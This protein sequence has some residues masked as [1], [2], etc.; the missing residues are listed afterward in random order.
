MLVNGS[1]PLT[2]VIRSAAF[3]ELGSLHAKD[4]LENMD[5]SPSGLKKTFDAVGLQPDL[6]SMLEQGLSKAKADFQSVG[7]ISQ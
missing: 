7:S 2:R 6:A 1:S 5:V 4:S 3:G